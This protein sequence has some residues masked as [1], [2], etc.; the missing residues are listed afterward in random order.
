MD[1]SEITILTQVGVC[2]AAVHYWLVVIEISI[3]RDDIRR[4]AEQIRDRGGRGHE[5]P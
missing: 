2:I 4:L 5:G 1:W 3:V